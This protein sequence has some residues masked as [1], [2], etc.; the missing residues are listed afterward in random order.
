MDRSYLRMVSGTEKNLAQKVPKAFI[1]LNL[2]RN[3][4]ARPEEN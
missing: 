4:E 3:P 2:S 1:A